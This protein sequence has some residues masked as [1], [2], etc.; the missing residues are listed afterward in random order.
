M[1]K[2]KVFT[3]RAFEYNSN[4]N[5]CGDLFKP[6]SVYCGLSEAKKKML[7]SMREPKLVQHATLTC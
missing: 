2:S 6:R 1:Y 7:N 5:T 3:G 4:T